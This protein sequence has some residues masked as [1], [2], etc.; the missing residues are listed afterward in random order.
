[1]ECLYNLSRQGRMLLKRIIFEDSY[2][3]LVLDT[4]IFSIHQPRYSI[5]KLFDTVL[6][7]SAGRTVF[8]GSPINVLPYFASHGFKCGEHEN[9][10]DFVLDVLIDSNG[11]SSKILQ[12][13]YL[14]STMCSNINT[15]MKSDTNENEDLSLLNRM[16]PRSNAS[17]FYYLAQRAARNAIRNPAVAAA[18]TLIA[19]SLAL[20]TGLLFYNMKA[21]VETGVSNRL[22]AIFFLAAH[23]VLVTASALE[24]LIKERALFIHVRQIKK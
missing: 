22:G 13:A 24:P 1:M 14:H 5:F 15:L 18:Q 11:R 6:F 12:K 17:E 2:F 8:F 16:E 3:V 4:I 7:L 23:Q 9:P 20:L 10:A 21:T 19:I